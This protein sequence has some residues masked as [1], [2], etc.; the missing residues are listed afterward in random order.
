M[1]L[2]DHVATKLFTARTL[3]DAGVVRTQRPDR[4]LRAGRALLRWGPTP[5]AGYAASAAR[6]PDEIGIVDDLGT[7]S[8]SRIHERTNAL[9][10]ALAG[11]GISEGDGVAVMARN[12]RGFVEATIAL[13]KLGAHGLY[14]NTAFAGP[15]ITDVCRR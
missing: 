12:H 1:N 3:I 11:R 14:L 7:L 2:V 9:A 4:L 8:F 10:D 15:Q 13:S 5:A 6:Y